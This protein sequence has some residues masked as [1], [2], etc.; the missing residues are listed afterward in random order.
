MDF[1]DL[2][3][4]EGCDDGSGESRMRNPLGRFVEHMYRDRSQREQQ[5][6]DIR[7]DPH[8]M[9]MRH[10][11]RLPT[12]TA[13]SQHQIENFLHGFDERKTNA[14]DPI[15]AF[16]PSQFEEFDQIFD[17]KAE[18]RSDFRNQ[19]SPEVPPGLLQ[20]YIRSF[21]DAA[22]RQENFRPV[23]IP[24]LENMSM[25]DKSKIRGRSENLARHLYPNS[26]FFGEEQVNAFLGTFGNT[27][28]RNRHTA[29]Q[30]VDEFTRERDKPLSELEMD[31]IFMQ[32]REAERMRREFED[33]RMNRDFE[34]HWKEAEDTNRMVDEFTG[35]RPIETHGSIRDIA[36]GMTQIND[37]KLQRSNFMNLMKQMSNGEVELRDND[38][39][40]K[41]GVDVMADEFVDWK[42]REG[43]MHN[44]DWVQE[45]YE[46]ERSEAESGGI[47]NWLS[48]YEQTD[49]AEE[50][51]QEFQKGSPT[52]YLSQYEMTDPADNPYMA[53][54]NPFQKGL[55]LFNEGDIEQAVLAFEAELH[56][57]PDNSIA[58]QHLG[59][60][61]AESD[62]DD[63]AIACLL[64]AIEADPKN[65]NAMLSLAV[66]YTND[67]YRDH[68]LD[69]L[70]T[71]IESHPDYQS[72]RFQMP[73]FE[74]GYSFQYHH[75]AVTEMFITAARMKPNNPDPDV[76]TALG[77]LFNLSNDYDKAVDCLKT[78]LSVKPDDYQS[79]NKLGATLANSSKSE[80]ALS[81]YFQALKI[82][83]S[84]VRARAN[85]GISFMALRDYEKAAQYFL[86]ALNMHPNSKHIWRN[87]QTAF[88]SM[89]RDDL[90]YKS[91]QQNLSLI[92][93]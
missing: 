78:A 28:V 3:S 90:V 42:D 58:W 93:I 80:E 34:S 21:I 59:Q 26:T 19:I 43:Q 41:D 37:P 11:N 74:Q 68:A 17:G 48:Q 6:Y 71:W 54:P 33:F 66:S 72:I 30:M 83:P 2:V 63:K 86:G 51:F 36:R 4:G 81:C 20:N 18:M 38:I 27:M 49:E 92:H 87:L 73:V 79:W 35:V 25:L 57:T 47:W 65:L 44:G 7:R 88:V 40:V 60:A 45:F 5:E 16:H 62:K 24:E 1:R 39:K 10:E 46:N 67:L 14:F 32:E 13:S 69:T 22:K 75:N 29:D 8:S 9:N 50:W 53:H 76:Q 15:G 55:E 64:K 91:T 77:L 85:L 12:Q 61:H 82:K 84:Y 31:Q 70:K 52:S 23:H 89:G 56:K